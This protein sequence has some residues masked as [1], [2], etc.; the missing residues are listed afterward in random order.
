MASRAAPVLR[1]PTAADVPALAG[2]GR[3]TF[4]GVFGH[5]YAA[6]DLAAFLAE[7][8]A[9]KV[10]AERI[11]DPRRTYRLA[12]VDGRLAGYVQLI[13]AGGLDHPTGAERPMTLA[14]L[15]CAADMTGRGIGAALLEWVLAEARGRGA[16]EL[17]LS[18]WSENYGAQRFYARYGFVHIADIDFMVG[19][20]RDH[21]F[22][23]ALKL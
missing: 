21:E 8:H 15:Y 19:R 11:A 5:L 2:F 6:E 17:R 13:L 23:Y 22:L 3:A 16:D 7:T 10:V 18:V 9:D 14:Q 12:E 1:A 20:H 4:T